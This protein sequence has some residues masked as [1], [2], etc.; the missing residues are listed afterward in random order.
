MDA[1]VCDPWNCRQLLEDPESSQWLEHV[2]KIL[3][4]NYILIR[5]TKRQYNSIFNILFP[6]N[7]RVSVEIVITFFFAFIN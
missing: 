3:L 4:Y 1:L 5:L 7:S 6:M 2:K